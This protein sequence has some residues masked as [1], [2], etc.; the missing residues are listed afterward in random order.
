MKVA[1]IGRRTGVEGMRPV[2]AAFKEIKEHQA[3]RSPS[4]DQTNSI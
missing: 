2:R 3:T 4:K 1:S